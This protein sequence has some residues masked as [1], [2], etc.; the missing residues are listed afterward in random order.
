VNNGALYLD[1]ADLLDHTD[2]EVI[3]TISSGGTGTVLAVRGFLPLLLD[4]AKPDIVTMVSSA[5]V[6]GH[7][8]SEAHDAFYAAKTA[9]AGFTEIVSKRLRPR[10]VR[11][12]S[13]YPPDFNNPDR[14]SPEW[15]E[16]RTSNDPLS[17]RSLVQCVLFAI[18]Q[19]R[20]CF[21]KAFHFEEPV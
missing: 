20:D 17:A 15:D 12:I 11:V 19:P 4:S 14:L 18:S 2:D 1:G 9:Q 7:A 6:P 5:G 13:L 3:N 16:P 10:G 8:R 21:I